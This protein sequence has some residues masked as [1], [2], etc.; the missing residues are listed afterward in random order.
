LAGVVCRNVQIRPWSVDDVEQ[1]DAI[2]R[3]VQPWHVATLQTQRIWATSAPARAHPLRLCVEVDGRVVS[4]A[5]GSLDLTAAEDHF[6]RVNVVTDPEFRHRGFGTALY[7]RIEDHL[8]GVGVRRSR[9]Y[10]MDEP[11]AVRWV[12]KQ[13]YEFGHSEQFSVV[14]PRKLARQPEQPPGVTVLS[15]AEAGLEA[16]Y[17]VLNTAA[18]DIPGDVR[19][20][21]I[22][23]DVFQASMWSVIDREISLVACADQV[24]AAVTLLEVNRSTGRAL[25]S[26]SGTLQRYRGRGL[27]K[28]IKVK[29]LHRAASAGVTAAFTASDST[30]H[31]MLAINAWLGYR[32]VGG[33]RAALKSL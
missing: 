31:G 21:G 16:V 24:P 17:H 28:L 11:E 26:G 18:F 6:G 20:A 12:A 4:F 14:D 9:G 32:N 33:T 30:N 13:G 22:D 8:L 27:V 7:E 10:A 25:S 2:R 23:L 15:A 29:S 19:W 5:Q 1:I 3:A